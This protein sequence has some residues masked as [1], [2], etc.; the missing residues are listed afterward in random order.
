MTIITVF[1]VDGRYILTVVIDQ[2]CLIS[3]AKSYMFATRSPGP[4]RLVWL[5]FSVLPPISR[6][7]YQSISRTY[8][9]YNTVV[10]RR[11]CLWRQNDDR[12]RDETNTQNGDSWHSAGGLAIFTVGGTNTQK[13][14]NH[15]FHNF[16]F[17]LSFLVLYL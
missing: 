7:P 17:C 13:P 11:Q 15:Y 14:E 1:F 3:N 5:F 10:K 12:F 6:I 9:D 8:C 2:S 16:I 4:R